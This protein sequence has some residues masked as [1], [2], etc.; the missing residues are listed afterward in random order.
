MHI[1]R[2]PIDLGRGGAMM[3]A[4]LLL[5]YQSQCCIG[6]LFV[7]L[8]MRIRCETRMFFLETATI[9][10][11]QPAPDNRFPATDWLM[12]LNRGLTEHQV[13]A[14]RSTSAA[15]MHSWW[16]HTY[17]TADAGITGNTHSSRTQR[18]RFYPPPHLYPLHTH[19][20]THTHIS[21]LPAGLQYSYETLSRPAC[22]VAAHSALQHCYRCRGLY[23]SAYAALEALSWINGRKSAPPF[24]SVE[25][26]PLDC[27]LPYRS[28]AKWVNKVSQRMSHSLDVLCSGLPAAIQQFN[29]V[30]TIRRPTLRSYGAIEFRL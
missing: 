15:P 12:D 18:Q 1:C 27:A 19:T 28:S 6:S 4:P 25:A 11:L 7:K 10:L 8:Y 21:R 13:Q 17:Y 9:G 20:H 22:L 26:S 23:V 14:A 16:R 3:P 29:R 2:Y 24:A 5:S 30:T